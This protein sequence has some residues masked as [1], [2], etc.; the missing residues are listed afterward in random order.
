MTLTARISRIGGPEVIEWVEQKPPAPGAGE[1]HLRHTAVGV[2]FIDTYHRSGLYGVPLPSGLGTEAAGVVEAM[3]SGVSCFHIG[4]RVAYAGGALGAYAQARV[5][6]AARLVR[7]PDAVSDEA[8]A[9]LMLKGMTA[10]YLLF[11]TYPLKRG[12]TALVHAAAG[13]VGSLLVPWARSL[14]ARVIG[15]AGGA[16]KCAL[17]REY[18]CDEVIDYTT[19]DFVTAVK[20]ITDGRGV[21]VV[22]DSVGKTTLP[23]SLDCL[24]R[25]GMLV[26]FGNASGKPAP[27]D[28]LTLSAKGSLFL[29]R[30]T[31][32]DY[33]ATR[34]ELLAAAG[35]L[36]EALRAGV[37][38]AD[39]RQRYALRDVAQAHADL[40]A[41]RT[42][43]TTLLMP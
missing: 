2:N 7:L 8:A 42:S 20:N 28:P 35:A 4:D 25:R 32:A 17:A 14:G 9:A 37:F 22:Y 43:G 30:P 18:G 39:V 13:G 27:V 24:R 38:K 26:S 40:E 16:T 12:E 5:V 31:L 1:V 34:E 3:G 21:D 36:F 15:T 41:R 11:L 19:A 29:T 23:G 10:Y 6:P 33:T